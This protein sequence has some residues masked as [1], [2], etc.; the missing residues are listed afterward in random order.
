[1]RVASGSSTAGDAEAAVGAAY[2]R[3][4]AGLGRPP[5]LLLVGATSRY[6]ARG[7]AAALA[8]RAPGVPV[9]G[10]S[11]CLG[12]MTD[13]GFRSDWGAGLALLGLSDPDGAYGVGAVPIGG[14]PRAAAVAAAR[15]ALERAGRPGEVPG[16]VLLT[17][18]PGHEERL[19][20]G[21]EGWFGPNV[22]I[23]GGS[24]ADEM[25]GANSYQIANEAALRD[26]VVVTAFF[27]SGEVMSSFHSGYEPTGHRG[28]VTKASG[29]T[30]LEIDG[31]PC[32]DVY[33]AWADG[34]F[35]HW[36]SEGSPLALMRVTLHPFGR[37]VGQAGGA[38]Y[39]VLSHAQGVTPEKGV[40][41]L[42]EFAE[43][44][45]VEL[46]RGTRDGLAMRAGRVIQSALE[47]ASASVDEV[48]GAL[49]VYC[50]GCMLTMYDRMPEIAASVQAALGGRPFLGV[51]SFGEQGCFVGGENRHGNLMICATLFGA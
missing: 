8:A 27:P 51:F 40:T 30:I 47:T 45:V 50:A 20:E 4:V 7:I 19:L 24:S 33:D 43:G 9:H 35:T 39:Y 17:A 25:T 28:V 2:D 34:V 31:R 26:S 11:S 36:V 3:V 15:Q 46:L 29:R 18:Q 49:V 32:G 42:T 37:V 16:L 5:D 14:D 41:F 38:P 1:M 23:A 12:V 13:E 10:S 22:V 6:D 44:E 48:A 21:L